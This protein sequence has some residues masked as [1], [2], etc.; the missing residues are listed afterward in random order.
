MIRLA[1]GGAMRWWSERV[2]PRIN[3]SSLGSVEV[4][5]LRDRACAGLRGT[6]VELGFGSGLNIGHYPAEVTSVVAVEPS[7]VHWA[8]SQDARASSPVPVTRAGSDAAH[9]TQPDASA[10]GVLS[11]FSLCVIPEIESAMREVVR[12]L[13]P[14]GSFH[15]VE[16][17]LSPDLRV[18]TW[19]RRLQPLNGALQDGCH[20]TRPIADLVSATTLD[21]E[22]IDTFY[23]PGPAFTRPMAY[24]TLGRA[25][26]TS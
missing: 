19:Q 1:L 13:K 15:F 16:H 21:V 18:Q 4:G 24:I 12:V 20:I 8:R 5:E 7:D 10:D 17:G 22:Q 9:L 26:K 23:L 14:G 2:V 25:R 11:S 3:D 6:V